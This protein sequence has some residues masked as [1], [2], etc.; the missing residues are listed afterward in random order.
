MAYKIKASDCTACGA[1]E[2]E[3]PNNAISFKKG[4]YAINADLCTECKGQFSSP[5]CASVCPADC[6]VRPDRPKPLSRP[7]TGEGVHGAHRHAGR[8]G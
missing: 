1:C 2:A 5:Q 6:C 8:G 7:I 4:A 3:C